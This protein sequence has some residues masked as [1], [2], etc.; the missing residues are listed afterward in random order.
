MEDKRFFIRD[1]DGTETE[2]EIV[3]TFTDPNTN[4]SYVV[5]KEPGDSDEV[6]A[7][8]YTEES[9]EHGTLVEIESDEEFDMIQEVLDAFT[10]EEE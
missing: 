6:L 5:Y 7:A 1:E 2:Y 8:R 4:I 9:P 3:L 10:E